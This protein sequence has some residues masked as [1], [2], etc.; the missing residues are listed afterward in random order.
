MQHVA[1]VAHRPKNL[2]PHHQDNQQPSQLHLTAADPMG[3]EDQRRRCADRDGAISD[4][5]REHVGA[6]HPHGSL[7][8]VPSLVGERVRARPALPKS[9]QGCQALD[10]VEEF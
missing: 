4:P 9:L 8:Q 5:A 2:D 7:K 10:R 1:Q 3:A 6:K